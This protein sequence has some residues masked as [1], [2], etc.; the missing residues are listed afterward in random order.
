MIDQVVSQYRIIQKLGAG[1]MGEVYLASDL[2]VGRR[3]ALK[4][5][6]DE[7][8][9]DEERLRRF[10]QE[11]RAASA[12]N[13]PNILTIHE[14][15]E[16]DGHQFI[17]TEFIDGESLRAALDRTGSLPADKALNIATQV[18]SALS[19]AHEAGL[20]HRDIKPDNI[21]VRRDGYVK[22]LDFGLAKL[23][24]GA[25]VDT[26]LPGASVPVRTVSGV[27]LGTPQYMSPEQ[28]TG[29][30]VDTR[31]DIFAF[32]AVLYEMVT[33]EQAFLGNSQVATVAAIL[34]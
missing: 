18:A 31:S 2:A 13:H 5:L 34:T 10:R 16:A 4:L 22:V 17:A 1:G 20:V 3:V 29:S 27:V 9:R 32:G 23:T 11:A 30:R 12:L 26:N 24:E 28:A 19:A 14:V 8:T 21:M 15:G 6:P 33:G 7:H 25:V